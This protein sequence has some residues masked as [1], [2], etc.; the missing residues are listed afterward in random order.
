M[1]GNLPA[2]PE[3]RP[4]AGRFALAGLL[5]F[6]IAAEARPDDTRWY[7]SNASGMMLEEIF[8]RL[9]ALKNDHALSRASGSFEDLAEE[10]KPYVEGLWAEAGIEVPS[11]EIRTLYEKG[12]AV[13]CQWIVRSGG[14]TR[15]LAAFGVSAELRAG[16][17]EL[18]DGQGLVAGEHQFMAGKETVTAYFYRGTSPVRAETLER[19]GGEERLLYTDRY[20]YRRSGSLRTAERRYHNEGAPV[21]LSF[22]EGFPQADERFIDPA[23]Y[24]MDML[25]SIHLDEGYRVVYDIDERG[26]VVSETYYDKEDALLGVLNNAWSGD[27]LDSVSWKGDEERLTEYE[28]DAEGNRTLERNYR[29]GIIE[30]TVERDG[31]N[32]REELYMDGKLILRA[33]WEDGRKISEER[34]EKK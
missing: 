29:N 32:D 15:G 12:K 6:F 22:R 13:R 20:R 5:L 28:Y 23:G 18:Y 4:C 25:E 34:I 11:V 1:Q 7:R 10:L 8:S 9:A 26:R 31:K 14:I 16:F 19:E 3:K 17:M 21:R 33:F 27:R 2:L 30:R 24:G